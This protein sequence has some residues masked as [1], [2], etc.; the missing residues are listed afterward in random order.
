MN[1]PNSIQKPPYYMLMLVLSLILFPTLTHA[2]APKLCQHPYA[3]QSLDAATLSKLL[4]NP[5]K[6]IIVGPGQAAD[7]IIN[8]CKANLSK[9]DLS[10]LDL[11]EIQFQQ[12]NFSNAKL[13]NT[14]FRWANLEKAN[15]YEA[16]LK[17]ASLQEAQAEGADFREADLRGADLSNG[18]FRNADFT[19]AN[20]TGANL[21]D[22][23]FTDATFHFANLTNANLES[24]NLTS[25]T[26]HNAKL[27]NVN[28]TRAKLN[29]AELNEADL[30][31]ADMTLTELK[32]AD[33]S[34][35]IIRGLKFQPKLGTTPNA[36]SFAS[37]IGFEEMDFYDQKLGAP[38]LTELRSAYKQLGMRSMERVLTAMLKRK[39]MS[40]AWNEG[41]WHY[42][43]AA[44]NYVFFYLTSDFGL[45]P[46]RPLKIFVIFIAVFAFPYGYAIQ[47]RSRKAGIFVKWTPGRF[48]NWNRCYDSESIKKVKLVKPISSCSLWHTVSLALYFSVISAFRI[49]WQD[50]NISHFITR[51]QSRPYEL[52]GHGWVQ[53]AVGIQSLLSIYLVIL[54]ALTYFARPFE[55]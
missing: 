26:F 20:L 44:F 25:A 55:W 51:M 48:K 35:A 15:F 36:V 53:T 27:I 52:L 4:K 9:Q 31:N 8:L 23:N 1:Q 43:E 32:N 24:A 17:K 10:G 18:D 47:K 37:S 22:G 11:T 50:I 14:Y 41:G 46:G 6:E 19:G 13:E 16:N 12:A 42:I 39:E 33:F 28:F 2:A 49:G 38:A 29:Q 5:P 3:N 21:Q 7:K 40:M 54:W 34:K 30:Q 45:A